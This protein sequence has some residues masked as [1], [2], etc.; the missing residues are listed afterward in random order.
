MAAEDVAAS[1]MMF[2][3]MRSKFACLPPAT[4]LSVSCRGT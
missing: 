3:S 2:H 1:V 4:K